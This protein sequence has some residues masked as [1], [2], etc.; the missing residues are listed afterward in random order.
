MSDQLLKYY[1]REL[2]YMRNMGA[3]FANRYPKVAG[4]LRMS[5]EV[6]EDPHVSRL[7]EGVSLLTAQVRRKLDD[8][9]PELTDGL[10]GMLY[11]DYQAPIPSMSIIQVSSQ[12][13]TDSAL[14]LPAQSVVESRNEGYKNCTF[15]TCY[16][17]DVWPISVADAS[18][19]NAP[20]KDP[21]GPFSKAQSMLR[22]NVTGEFANVELKEM[23][24]DRLRFHLNGQPQVTLPLYQLIFQSALGIAIKSGAKGHTRY[25]QPRH[26]KRVGFDSQQAVVPYS[27]RSFDGYRLLVEQ[28]AFP[29]KFL[30][31]ELDELLPEWLGDDNKVEITLFFSAPSETLTKQLNKEHVLLGCT[32][33][34]NLFEQKMETFEVK[35]ARYEYQLTPQYGDA[36]AREVIKID[37]VEAFDHQGERLQLKPF[38]SE[39]HPRYSNQNDL[40]WSSRRELVS[41][42]GGFTEPGHETYLSVIDPEAQLVEL[43]EEQRLVVDVT[44]TCSNR[45]LASRLPFGVGQP[46]LQISAK[47]DLI[48]SVRCLVPP[49]KPIRPALGE[50]TRW[51]LM[52]NLCLNDFADG[53]SRE[54]LV[55]CL[56]LYDFTS[57]PQTAS[58]IDAIHSVEVK[59]ATSRVV[60]KGRVAFCHG[61]EVI[62]EFIEDELSG[63]QLFFFGSVLSEFFSLFAAVNSFTQLSI[64]LRYQ[65]RH[66]HQWPAVSGGVP[67]L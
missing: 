14:K 34:I 66:F 21:V 41:W 40:Y 22:L 50:A 47:A 15:R 4:R 2:S 36:D 8:S 13:L 55:D 30:F 62:I 58:M 48:K 27:K 39:S 9:F 23:G 6:V 65:N 56:K 54:I 59:P 28:F 19:I 44:A 20:F 1:N 32:P 49:T 29:E 7:L 11:P 5:E 51:Q 10:L 67:L 53:N 42:A 35:P 31:F 18:F 61:S 3:E 17:T 43:E 25:L 57:S 38:Y 37:N 45:N 33:I 64:K 63:S 12:N 46:K 16:E 60:S 24:I 26:L 52:R